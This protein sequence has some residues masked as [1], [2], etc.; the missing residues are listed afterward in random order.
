MYLSVS[1]P[2]EYKVLDSNKAH[3]QHSSRRS[4]LRLLMEHGQTMTQTRLPAVTKLVV[5]I[6][7]LNKAM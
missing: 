7:D 3:A 4:P 6:T 2:D 5:K 1:A